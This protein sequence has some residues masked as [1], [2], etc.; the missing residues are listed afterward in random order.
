MISPV[1]EYILQQPADIQIVLYSV[2]DVIKNEMPEIAFEKLSYQM[3]TFDVH[4]NCVHFAVAKN[5]IGFYPAPSGILAF[6]DVI[7]KKNLKYSKG[8]VQFPLHEPLPLDLIRLITKFRVEE[9]ISKYNDKKI[10]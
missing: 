10:K 6:E 1:D 9:N 3:P 4:G 5:H 2:R 8:A 7:K